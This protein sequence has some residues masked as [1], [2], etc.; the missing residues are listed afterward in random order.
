MDPSGTSCLCKNAS[1]DPAFI[2][3]QG[4]AEKTLLNVLTLPNVSKVIFDDL[5]G[6][7]KALLPHPALVAMQYCACSLRKCNL[8]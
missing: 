7:D 1:L 8:V 5:P 3:C 6:Y 2:L 4:S